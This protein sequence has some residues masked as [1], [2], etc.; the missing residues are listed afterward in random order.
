MTTDPQPVSKQLAWI[1]NDDNDDRWKKNYHA[2]TATA[3][4]THP[5][6]KIDL[7]EATLEDLEDLIAA[8]AKRLA[9][10]K[11]RHQ[12][13]MTDKSDNEEEKR[14]NKSAIVSQKV[15]ASFSD[16][17]SSTTK[18]K[19]KSS[20]VI[21]STRSEVAS[22]L[23]AKL[24][25]GLSSSTPNLHGSPQ[26]AERKKKDTV[27]RPRKLSTISTTKDQKQRV[28]QQQKT[29]KNQ[30]VIEM[31]LVKNSKKNVSNNV[32]RTPTSQSNTSSTNTKGEI[33]RAEVQ[34]KKIATEKTRIQRKRGKTLPG[35]L[36]TPIKP[37]HLPPLKI[38]PLDKKPKTPTRIP[39]PVTRPVHP[40]NSNGGDVVKRK[41]TAATSTSLSTRKT[42]KKLNPTISTTSSSTTAIAAKK[43]PTLQTSRSHK[44][45]DLLTRQRK[46][47]ITNRTKSIRLEGSIS[48]NTAYQKKKSSSTIHDRLQ[49]IV[50]ESKSWPSHKERQRAVEGQTSEIVLRGKGSR[51]EPKTIIRVAMSPQGN[52]VYVCYIVYI[53]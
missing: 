46:Q 18:V 37:I 28:Q 5:T 11:L 41:S 35:G 48:T 3:A 43:Q 44:P 7:S 15:N 9:G 19:R 33:K 39:L 51:E 45:E 38:E 12:A 49:G 50:D 26:L 30:D 4:T 31:N 17:T 10:Y 40:N 8:S 53:D 2:K 24:Q 16:F 6:S 34:P 42:V 29:N 21:T 47:S 32:T 13:L 14:P 25:S 20:P 23:N 27:V 22:N 36:V 1:S 52:T